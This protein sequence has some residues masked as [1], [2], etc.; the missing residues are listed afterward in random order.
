MQA[1][2]NI[3]DDPNQNFKFQL[4]DGSIIFFTLNYIE[5]QSGWFFTL[6][7]KTFKVTNRRIVCSPNMLRA[8]R[9]ILSPLF[10]LA[11][12]TT[13]GELMYEPIYRDDFKSGR[14]VLNVLTAE[15]VA[16][17]EANLMQRPT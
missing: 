10:G 7:Y 5:N 12:Y 11:V 15:D 2:K 13:D 9:R 16:W 6:E 8:Y 1:I 3:T 17:V 4:P 14:A